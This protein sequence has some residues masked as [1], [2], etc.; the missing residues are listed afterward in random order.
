M[1]AALTLCAALPGHASAAGGNPLGHVDH[2]SGGTGGFLQVVGW[3]FDPDAPSMPGEI[4]VSIDGPAGSGARSVAVTADVH[5]PDVADVFPG[6]SAAHGFSA[7]IPGVAPGQ[8]AV[9]V[10][11]VNRAGD[12][13]NGLIRTASVDVPATP[14]GSPFGYFDEAFS[15]PLGAAVRGWT[16]DPDAM[17]APTEVHVYVDGP[18]GTGARGISLGAATAS[19]P[20]VA[21]GVPGA[22]A[23]HGYE[24][25]I[26][27]LPPGNHAFWVYAIN[28]AGPGGNPLLG[29]RV[30]KT[31]DR[32]SGQPADK[33]AQG[34][35]GQVTA[36]PP[37]LKTMGATVSYAFFPQR[38]RRSTRFSGFR[39]GNVPKGSTVTGR[40]LTAAGRPCTGR[41]KPGFLKTGA[42]GSLRVNAFDR[43]YPAGTRLEVVISNPAYRS[44]IKTVFVRANRR[45]RIATRCQTPGTTK[46][47]SC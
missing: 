28:A 31:G 43:R 2:I 44:Q 6:V 20:D 18:A 24:R 42:R 5:R 46:R 4:Q 3:T 38:P 25:A 7:A 29:S 22:G 9:Y 41:R 15:V 21:A 12:G 27:D 39:V 14:A 17:Q 45:P 8:H 19:R 26:A 23:A 40:C 16:A 35:P 1:G 30:V 47:G 32:V 13:T 11:S 37:S 36:P 33:P 10:Y 34:G